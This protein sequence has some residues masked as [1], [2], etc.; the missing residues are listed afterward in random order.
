MAGQDQQA[1]VPTNCALALSV[2]VPAP[3]LS[4]STVAWWARRWMT[5]GPNT[6]ENVRS[7]ARAFAGRFPKAHY[8]RLSHSPEPLWEFLEQVGQYDFRRGPPRI[9]V[10]HVVSTEWWFGGWVPVR[11]LYQVDPVQMPL[12]PVLVEGWARLGMVGADGQFDFSLSPAILADR[13][14]Q[15]TGWKVRRPLSPKDDAAVLRERRDGFLQ[16]TVVADDAFDYLFVL[17]LLTSPAA[18]TVLVS[19]AR[20]TGEDLAHL[21]DGLEPDWRSEGSP[22]QF[23]QLLGQSRST[24]DS[25]LFSAGP[26]VLPPSTSSEKNL[27]KIV[28][29]L[30]RMV[31]WLALPD[32]QLTGEL[33]NRDIFGGL[34]GPAMAASH[35]YAPS[36]LEDWLAIAVAG[37]LY[38]LGHLVE[39]QKTFSP[40]ALAFAR[41]KANL[42]LKYFDGSTAMLPAPA[43]AP[44]LAG[45]LPVLESR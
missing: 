29:E 42:L 39:K 11:Q 44:S 7:R 12:A 3:R 28:G 26:I 2:P 31:R 5:H 13:F 16:R 43:R 14:T 8:S 18:E 25:W 22:E 33:L 36:R 19:Y 38:R 34:T 20:F 41:E 37:Q 30:K 45:P 15:L 1:L 10:R 27:E 21:F 17:P 6:R 40:R 9:Q 23:L 35:D 32:E 4:V 24:R